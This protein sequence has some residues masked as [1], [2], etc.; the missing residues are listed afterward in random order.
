MH[1]QVQA[2]VQLHMHARMHLAH[3]A[4]YIQ[5]YVIQIWSRKEHQQGCLSIISCYWAHTRLSQSLL[6]CN[7]LLLCK[8]VSSVISLYI[9]VHTH[10]LRQRKKEAC[11]GPFNRFI[12]EE[13]SVFKTEWLT[14]SISISNSKSTSFLLNK[15]WLS[16][17]KF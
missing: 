12:F 7:S 6:M 11:R 9:F 17:E 15:Y 14:G 4:Y 16:A 8:S 5:I 2:L 10:S 13:L 1:Y 3:Y